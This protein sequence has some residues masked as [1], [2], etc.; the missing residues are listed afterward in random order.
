MISYNFENNTDKDKITPYDGV[1]DKLRITTPEEYKAMTQEQK[2]NVL[3][4]M[5]KVIREINVYPTYF[6]N[7]KGIEKEIK[8]LTNKE[9][10][11]IDGKLPFNNSIGQHLCRQFFPNMLTVE[12]PT[13]NRTMWNKFYDDHNL[14][15]ILDFSIRNEI[16]KPYNIHRHNNIIGGC[17]ASN[18]RPAV[19]KALYEHY[20]PKNGIIYD[21]ASGFSGRLLGALCS[22]NNYTYIGV[23]PNSETFDNLNTFGNVIESVTKRKNSF[24]IVKSGSEDFKLSKPYFDFAFSSPPY[25][26]CE[27]YSDEGTQSTNKFPELESW[28]EGYVKPTIENIYFMLK[29]N[30]YYGVN[31]ADFNLG[32]NKK[33]PVHLVDRWFDLSI[34]CGFEFVE[35]LEMKLN[36]RRGDGFSLENKG[37]TEGV[38]IFKK[39]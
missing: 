13:D 25:F 33:K 21:Y 4:E 15:R 35:K 24:K 30:S 1:I 34:E 22:N 20:V 16:F 10:P 28:F 17:A 32:G 5:L 19:A 9:F 29:P 18:F 6:Y 14:K 11:I 37:K 12:S 38:Y 23:E 27:I 26:T 2:D 39:N 3:D 8:N 31:I 7:Q 36:P